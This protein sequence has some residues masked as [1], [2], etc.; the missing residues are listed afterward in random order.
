MTEDKAFTEAYGKL[1]KGQKE[2]VDTI[3]GP[4][5]VVAGPGTGK[6]QI[7]AVRI[8]NILKNVPGSKPDEIVALTYTE[9]AVASMR[10]RLASLIGAS[11]YRVRIHT[12]HG[13]AR[14][15]LELRPDLFPRVATGTQ[16]NEVSSISLIE[17]LLDKGT[18]TRIRNPKDP[19][20]LAKKLVQFI[21][22]LKREHYT[23][24]RYKAELTQKLEALM[25][26]PER[27]H[28]KGAHKGKEK[29]AHRSLREKIEKHLE[30]ADL[31]S[32]Y[33]KTLETESLYDYDDLIAEAV[34]GLET[35]ED[36]RL[37]VGERIQFVLADEHQDANTAQNK[38][39][40]LVTD[41]DGAPNLFL[42]GD[43]KQAIYRFQGASLASF[44]YFKDKYPEA[45]IIVL[46]EN[47]RSTPEILGAAHDLIA[48]APIPY[49]ELRTP[50][51]P[52]Q[53]PGVRLR[54]APK[55]TPLE[56]LHELARYVDSL[57]QKGIAHSDIA[58]LTRTNSDVLAIADYL[59]GVGIPEDHATAELDALT[60]PAVRLFIDLVR[61]VADPGNSGALGR[62]LF[63]PGF[64]APLP[65]R[66]R[67]L[68]TTRERKPL[69]D[70]LPGAHPDIASWWRN[71]SYLG[72]ELHTTPALSWLA[73]LAS[74]SGFLGGILS[75]RESE[76]A[77]SAYEAF[78]EEVRIVSAQ[79]PSAT[80][81]DVLN[82]ID[83]IESHELSIK[84]ARTKRGGV[85]VM[86]AHHAKGMEFPYVA[87]AFASDERWLGKRTDELSLLI[88]KEDD[89][90]DIRRLFYVA[91][92]RA[93]KE[94]LITYSLLNDDARAQTPLRFL[95]DLTTH[96]EEHEEKHAVPVRAPHTSAGIL[97]TNLLKERFLAQGFSP[98][99]F[100][101][102]MKSPWLYLFRTLLQIPD[103]PNKY[104]QFGTAIHAGLKHHA[105]MLR[106]GK[107]SLQST[108]EAF[109]AELERLPLSERDREGLVVQGT[110]AL[111][112][113]LGECEVGMK[114]IR[115]SEFPVTVPFD[116]AGL[117]T[118]PLSGK[119]DRIDGE[120]KNVTV[121]DYKTGKAK[122]ENE[123]RGLTKAEN[124]DYYR[125]LIFYKLMLERDGRYHMDKGA[126]HFV[127]PNDSQKIVIREFTI[128]P[129]E[130][131]ELQ[132]EIQDAA[133]AIT[134]G[135]AFTTLPNPEDVPGYESLIRILANVRQV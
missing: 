24:E 131:E 6:T 119:L 66:L 123:I 5:M 32:A 122:S 75:M 13:F 2:A 22:V 111:T 58:I 53:G 21:S 28:E 37:E 100:N 19:Y 74:V 51:I 96:L 98:T 101:N 43:E 45:K 86:T 127:E 65:P 76:D 39:L 18:Y 99:G 68:A 33:T 35:N 38:L 34:R 46:G 12:F 106:E 121:V 80:A 87:I 126:L 73:N 116:I 83:L 88:E 103:A 81:Q 56:E 1:N 129:E 91:L 47:Y 41:F 29:V 71:V 95:A 67:A 23:P 72:T 92:T 42:V 113:Y 84:R 30:V 14:L 4:V 128:T 118:I 20:R 135:E 85:S 102:Y 94:V 26:D 48:P 112:A 17:T 10:T 57:V 117:G 63:I 16:L 52:T 11:A 40:E 44:F 104:M 79:K 89:E 107:A 130:V 93:K 115:E 90:H 3:Y 50:L 125:Q 15:I 78:M 97:D 55:D 77:Y 49:P 133:T 108:I 82:H 60:H 27:V 124:R 109:T 8:A 69:A 31:F 64:P 36:F 9:S 54:V 114:A 62:A 25:Q 61:A 120:G 105:D 70:I 132:K 110:E 7:L 59:R 134:S